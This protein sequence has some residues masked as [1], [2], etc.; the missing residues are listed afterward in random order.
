MEEWVGVFWAA[1]LAF[2]AIILTTGCLMSARMLKPN[3]YVGVRTR[4]TLSDEEAWYRANA[5]AGRCFVLAGVAGVALLLFS[6]AM[7]LRGHPPSTVL[8]LTTWSV[9]L[10]S[11]AALLIS[12]WVLKRNGL[13]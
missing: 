4:K 13:W 1:F 12:V 11:L 9:L 5:L 7:L 3:P 8:S 6:G 10:T 2:E